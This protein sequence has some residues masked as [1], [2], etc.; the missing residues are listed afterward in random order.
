VFTRPFATPPPTGGWWH[1][2]CTSAAGSVDDLDQEKTMR[3]HLKMFLMLGALAI[4]PVAATATDTAQG[5]AATAKKHK[6]AMDKGMS[7]HDASKAA[8]GAKPAGDAAA[9]K[10]KQ[11]KH[12]EAMDEG[13]S[14]QDASKMAE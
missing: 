8:A 14:H 3:T 4:A 12:K 11:K 6:E 10:A 9:S 13:M 7:H 5:D 2:R 1:E